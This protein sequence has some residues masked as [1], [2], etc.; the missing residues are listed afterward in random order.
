MVRPQSALGIIV[1]D[2]DDAA[3]APIDVL[4]AG[5]DDYVSAPLVWGE[6]LARVR[7]ILRRVRRFGGEPRQIMLEDRAIDLKAHKIK[8]PNGLVIH[9]T[10]KEF[11]VLRYLVAHAN[12]ALTHQRLAQTVWQRDGRGDVEYLRIV[13][14]QLRRKLEPDPVNPRYI[15]TERS[16]GYRF[17]MPPAG[18]RSATTLSS[19]L[20]LAG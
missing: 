5:A 20:L 3:Q 18:Q 16:V 1:L 7:A 17:Q 10:P 15:R 2:H 8:R 11:L 19:Q 12:Q 13:I 14:K 9:L 6:L 4:N